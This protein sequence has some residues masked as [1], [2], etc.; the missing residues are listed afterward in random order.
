MDYIWKNRGLERLDIL[1]RVRAQPPGGPAGGL[2]A[3]KKRQY[4]KIRQRFREK[5][6]LL[7]FPP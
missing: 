4:A 1:W 7:P 2:T 6:A 3:D 5:K